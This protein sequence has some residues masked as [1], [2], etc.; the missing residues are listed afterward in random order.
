MR[1]AIVHSCQTI[2]A[3][4]A[5]HHFTISFA[6]IALSGIICLVFNDATL[7]G[8][9]VDF[10]N[11]IPVP[12][13]AP[14]LAGVAVGLGAGS[15]IDSQILA[16]R[17]LV[18]PRMAWSTALIFAACTFMTAGSA[19][20][21]VGGASIIRNGLIF[22]ALGIGSTVYF[23]PTGSWIGPSVAGLFLILFGGARPEG[24]PVWAFALQEDVTTVQLAIAVGMYFV[25]TLLY[26]AVGSTRRVRITSTWT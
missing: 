17:S 14:M 16:G 6:M 7:T 4:L 20:G 1:F 12:I 26:A 21:D 3:W 24:L 25:V 18:V 8:L 5:V 15:R 22:G 23:G 9:V 13:V 19:P 11:P 10:L 2:R